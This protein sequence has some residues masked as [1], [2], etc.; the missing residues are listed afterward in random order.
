[1]TETKHV[2]APAKES[3]IASHKRGWWSI[4]R[5][6]ADERVVVDLT[7]MKGSCLIPCS[8]WVSSSCTCSTHRLSVFWPRQWLSV[9]AAV[10]MWAALLLFITTWIQHL[11]SRDTLLTLNNLDSIMLQDGIFCTVLHYEGLI[12]LGWGGG[13]CRN[14]VILLFPK[15][16]HNNT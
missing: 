16:L 3:Y 8:S 6:R 4:Q 13:E 7:I 2:A 12:A 1:M 5:D 11:D 10:Q 9:S 15:L 14:S